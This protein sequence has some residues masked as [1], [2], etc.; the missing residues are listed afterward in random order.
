MKKPHEQEW[1]LTQKTKHTAPEITRDDG[2]RVATVEVRY[3]TEGR[4]L[5]PQFKDAMGEG[6]LIAAAPD[7][8][9]ELAHLVRLLEPLEKEGGLDVPGL[10][11][12]NGARAAL[13]KA[14][15]LP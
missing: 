11:T 14:G 7:L 12:L 13:K 1:R 9:R 15:V 10:A 5:V 8:Y 3:S 2:A 6:A 4:Y